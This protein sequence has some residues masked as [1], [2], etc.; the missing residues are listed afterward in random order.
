MGT[1]R[2]RGLTRLS[3]VLS[4]PVVVFRTSV[5]VGLL[6]SLL[7]SSGM[8]VAGLHT[9]GGTMWGSS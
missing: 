6:E 7:S 9:E 3:F 5:W 1:Y 2:D 4:V 8:P